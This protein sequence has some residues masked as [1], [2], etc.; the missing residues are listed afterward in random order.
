MSKDASYPSASPLKLVKP[1]P[2]KVHEVKGMITVGD[3][4]QAKFGQLFKKGKS[5]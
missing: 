5:S 3:Y 2:M 1:K 4:N